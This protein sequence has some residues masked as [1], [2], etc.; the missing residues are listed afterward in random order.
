LMFAPSRSVGYGSISTP[1]LSKCLRIQG[2]FRRFQRRGEQ[3]RALAIVPR[4]M[5]FSRRVD[6]DQ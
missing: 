3:G 4:P 5:R 6:L 1:G 2:R